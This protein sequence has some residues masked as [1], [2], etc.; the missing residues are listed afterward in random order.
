MENHHW[1]VIQ[2]DKMCLPR[3]GI[4][5]TMGHQPWQWPRKQAMDFSDCS[6]WGGPKPHTN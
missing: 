3:Y 1:A 5:P 4:S 2:Y 6:V